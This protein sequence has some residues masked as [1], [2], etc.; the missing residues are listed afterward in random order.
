MEHTKLDKFDE[1]SVPIPYTYAII[2]GDS[3]VKYYAW[4]FKCIFLRYQC[5]IRIWFF[6][7][8][9]QE[10][11][12]LEIKYLFQ[13]YLIC[14]VYKSHDFENFMLTVHVAWVQI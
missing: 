5:W 8:Q 12:S 4:I 9:L 7:L 1:F 2:L 10:L 11:A 6:F 3:V 13:N 14:L